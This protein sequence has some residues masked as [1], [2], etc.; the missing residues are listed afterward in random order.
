MATFSADPADPQNEEPTSSASSSD[1]SDEEGDEYLAKAL[2]SNPYL[3]DLKASAKSSPGASKPPDAAE[4]PAVADGEAT[5]T[6]DA[7]STAAAAVG[8]TLLVHH[9]LC[10]LHSI[11][12]HPERP[13]RVRAIMNVLTREFPDFCPQLAPEATLEQVPRPTRR[14][15]MPH[16]GMPQVMMQRY[17]MSHF[18]SRDGVTLVAVL[19]FHDQPHVDKIGRVC[20]EVEEQGRATEAEAE[21][22]LSGGT[23]SKPRRPSGGQG[24]RGSHRHVDTVSI[25]PDTAVMRT[26]RAAIWRAAG[27]ACFA[28][29]EVMSGRAA[30]AFCCVRPPGHHAEPDRAM[31]FCFF[32]NAPIG[33]LHAQASSRLCRVAVIDI[34]VH[35]GNGTQAFFRNDPTTFYAS[36]HQGPDFYPGTGQD[37]IKGVRGNI[38]NVSMREGEGSRQ[39]RRAYSEKILPAL[40]AFQ[41]GLIFISA[42]FDAHE[43]DPLAGI[44]L[45]ELD[46]HWVTQQICEVAKKVCGGR[47]VSILEGGYN[48]QAIANSSVAHVLALRE[49]A[50]AA[51]LSTSS[52][53][54]TA[55]VPGSDGG[56]GGEGVD[57]C[58]VDDGL[59]EKLEAA[60]LVGEGADGKGGDGG[61]GGGGGGSEGED[62]VSTTTTTTTA[63]DCASAV[64]KQ[65]DTSA[66]LAAPSSGPATARGG[67]GGGLPGTFPSGDGGSLDSRGD[68]ASPPPPLPPRPQQCFIAEGGEFPGGRG[69][70]ES[71]AAA[72]PAPSSGP[73]TS[74]GGGVA[75]FPE[76]IL[77]GGED[78]GEGVLR[79][80]GGPPPPLPPRPE[81]LVSEGG[82]EGEGGASGSGIVGGGSAAAWPDRE[83]DMDEA[84]ARLSV[85]DAV[86]LKKASGDGEDM[87]SPV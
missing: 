53:A 3:Q 73:A 33:A 26:S 40:E 18:V 11:P 30:N 15:Y 37:F 2:A 13:G 67:G 27:A 34:D 35:H 8:G 39:F 47:V 5:Q 28:V 6:E 65:G 24:R 54:D 87:F 56:D 44:S 81:Q 79:S 52:K 12:D 77:P 71:S 21:A 32:N 36:S 48:L 74:S 42:G 61:G 84:F 7:P 83:E 85:R 17:I 43:D 14:I 75:W 59:A 80:D 72:R 16:V 9:P 63:A 25:D 55:T 45:D 50:A 64:F 70:G 1:W 68:G 31:G 76:A 29:D 86:L 20:S 62:G 23:R 41:P 78:E 51:G 46:Y 82:R 66:M 69:M 19:R 57:R 49:A 38:L 60:N 10:E 22:V 58:L 4:T